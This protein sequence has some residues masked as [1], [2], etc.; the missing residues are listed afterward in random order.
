[1]TRILT[2]VESNFF[3]HEVALNDLYSM[4]NHEGEYPRAICFTKRNTLKQ[5]YITT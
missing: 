4:L 3:T 5:E 2:Y 1:M